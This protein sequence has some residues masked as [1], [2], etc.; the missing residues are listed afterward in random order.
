MFLSS[1]ARRFGPPQPSPGRG[2]FSRETRQ[3][4]HHQ[5]EEF[6]REELRRAQS[7]HPRSSE[8]SLAADDEDE[9]DKDDDDNDDDDDFSPQKLRASIARSATQSTISAG[10]SQGHHPPLNPTLS[11][12]SITRPSGIRKSPSK[13][14]SSP[15]KPI[16]ARQFSPAQ[17]VA[18]P[19]IPPQS[20]SLVLKIGK[21]GRAKTEM[22]VVAEPPVPSLSDS[23]MG[24]DIS[25]T[26]PED[27]SDW[28]GQSDYAT[29][30]GNP[31][32]SFAMPDAG[33]TLLERSE[34]GSRPPSK[35]SSYSSNTIHSGRISPWAGSSQ[36]ENRRTQY[37]HASEGWKR[38]P[39]KRSS[40]LGTS[41]LAN[42][43]PGAVDEPDEEDAGDAQHALR[44]VLKGRSRSV[45]QHHTVSG[46]RPR[47]NRR[48][49]AAA[50]LRS[51]PPPRFGGDLDIRSRGSNASPTTITDPDL[52][53]PNSGRQNNPSNATRCICNSMD[54][55]GHL[56]IQW[57]YCPSLVF[58]DILFI[59]LLG[60]RL[61]TNPQ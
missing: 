36:G 61:L 54:N 26:G 38:T 13:G 60:S 35:G 51:S 24:S 9:D 1:P 37:R 53:T 52:A 8:S 25:G 28:V 4:Y 56:M 17:A 22:Q 49:L 58:L 55:G 12:A 59:C 34:S 33:R 42:S 10:S 18:A 3:P 46:Y 45:K 20:Q 16:R 47:A 5:T 57:Y 2:T 14:R 27:E 21:D 40:I 15:V 30:R 19:G 44:Q 11:S 7:G 31:P 39:S 43:S 41:E 48:S 32:S 50:Q 29:L 6:K 23:F